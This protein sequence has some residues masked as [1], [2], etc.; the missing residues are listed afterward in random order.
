MNTKEY[1][2]SGILESYVLGQCSEQEQQEVACL[3][4]IYPEIKQELDALERAFEGYLRADAPPAPEDLWE[5]LEQQL[6][7]R[8]APEA[9]V[10]APDNQ[11]EPS[12][13]LD[14]AVAPTPKVFQMNYLVTLAA[15]ASLVFA[16]VALWQANKSRS[17]ATQIEAQ[18]IAIQ[19]LEADLDAVAQSAQQN[20]AV[21]NAINQVGTQRIQLNGTP[22]N[23]PEK[24][25]LVY[26]NAAQQTVL[27]HK[28]SLPQNPENFQ[29]QLW[30]LVDGT[31]VDLGVFDALDNSEVLAMKGI[32]KAQAF[33]ITLETHGGNPT[34]NL[35]MLFAIGNTAG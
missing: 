23:A 8:V 32:G 17:A 29:Y 20:L 6:P 33:A 4:K 34:P 12:I 19:Q 31:P 30:A 21:L 5:S 2:A 15:A 14:E 24:A 11:T 10:L 27:V 16:F 7:N 28:G 18:A 3:S 35:E 9:S 25:A 1:I 13:D 22:N 26:W